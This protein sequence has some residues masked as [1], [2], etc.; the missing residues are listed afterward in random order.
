MWIIQFTGDIINKNYLTVLP[1]R[2]I[3]LFW[4]S[5]TIVAIISTNKNTLHEFMACSFLEIYKVDSEWKF[6]I[7]SKFMFFQVCKQTVTNC[8]NTVIKHQTICI[9]GVCITRPHKHAFY[10]YLSQ[11]CVAN[12]ILVKTQ[13]TIQ[14]IISNWKIVCFF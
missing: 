14:T 1:C 13:I 8:N 9:R 11:I 7:V 12:F 10:F 6:V 4:E 5:V 2:F 3:L